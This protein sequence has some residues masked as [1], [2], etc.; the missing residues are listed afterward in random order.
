M[1]NHYVFVYVRGQVGLRPSFSWGFTSGEMKGLS[2]VRLSVF[3][4]CSYVRNYTVRL[5]SNTFTEF[6]RLF[7]KVGKSG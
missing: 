3:V 6:Y 7:R 2:V 5:F 1:S 4:I